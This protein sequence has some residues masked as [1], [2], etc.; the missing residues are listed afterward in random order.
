MEQQ[1]NKLYCPLCNEYLGQYNPETKLYKPHIPKNRKL[2]DKF[3]VLPVIFINEDNPTEKYNFSENDFIENQE[4]FGENDK[5]NTK[6]LA[7]FQNGYLNSKG[8]LINTNR[9]KDIEC[10]NYF[11]LCP[12]CKVHYNFEILRLEGKDDPQIKWA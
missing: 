6:R 12:K 2:G 11:T 5:Q 4:I 10:G 7:I 3:F 9:T 8:L 1:P